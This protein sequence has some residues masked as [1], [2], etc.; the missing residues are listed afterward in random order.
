[1]KSMKSFK[2]LL[3]TTLLCGCSQ[4]KIDYRIYQ[5]EYL[6]LSKDVP[7]QTKE[8]IYVPQ[9]DETWH[10]EK[11]VSDLRERIINQK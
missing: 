1:M 9:V 6:F 4:N 7:I 2:I 3:L 5:P 11:T 8:G 10:S